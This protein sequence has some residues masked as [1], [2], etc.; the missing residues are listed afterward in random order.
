MIYSPVWKW[1]I[2]FSTGLFIAVANIWAQDLIKSA[3]TLDLA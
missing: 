1:T 2:A 3:E